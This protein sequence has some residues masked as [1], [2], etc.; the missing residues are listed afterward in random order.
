MA[1]V[2]SY[3][4]TSL[5]FPSNSNDQL[6]QSPHAH[7]DFHSLHHFPDSIST[8]ELVL[9][10]IGAMVQFRIGNSSHLYMEPRRGRR[11][12]HGEKPRRFL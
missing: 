2:F 8:I 12:V 4:A 5:H 3:S 9:L 1:S 6:T 7:H 10:R 11:L